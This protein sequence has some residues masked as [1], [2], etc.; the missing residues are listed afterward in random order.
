[1][2]RLRILVQTRRRRAPPVLEHSAS[3]APGLA[4]VVRRARRPAGPAVVFAF[5]R[6][7]AGERT[8]SDHATGNE[9]ISG[10]AADLCARAVLRLHLC[11]QRGKGEGSMV[12]PEIAGTVLPRGASDR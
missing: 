5:P 10:Q 7:V 9:S 3:A 4:D 6:T 12:G 8:H 11:R 1:M 2:A